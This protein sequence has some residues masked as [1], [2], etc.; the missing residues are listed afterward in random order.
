MDEGSSSAYWY[1]GGDF[2]PDGCSV[3]S[4]GGSIVKKQK[5]AE[6][7]AI[8]QTAEAA[9]AEEKQELDAAEAKKRRKAKRHAMAETAEEGKEFDTAEAKKHAEAMAAEEQRELGDAGLLQALASRSGFHLL[10]PA[11]GARRINRDSSFQRLD[12]EHGIAVMGSRLRCAGHTHG[13]PTSSH[14][15]L[16]V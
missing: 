15:M 8:A 16:Q 5:K 12:C 10:P 13:T 7:H 3:V 1:P 14:Q 6:R 4:S 11:W 9:T 2:S